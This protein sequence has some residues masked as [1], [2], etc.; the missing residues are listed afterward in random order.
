LLNPE[1]K[2]GRETQSER[3]RWGREKEGKK[4]EMFLKKW[5]EIDRKM[6]PHSK[7]P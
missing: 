2:R 6:N 5:K 7:V 3:E 4:D 1:C